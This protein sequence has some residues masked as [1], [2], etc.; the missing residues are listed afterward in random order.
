MFI[1]DDGTLFTSAGFRLGDA[2]GEILEGMVSWGPEGALGDTILQPVFDFEP[3]QLSAWDE[4]GRAASTSVPFSP[5]IVWN[6]SHNRDVICGISRDYRFEIRS[7]DGTVTIIERDHEPTEV[8]ADEKLWYERAKIAQMRNI[9]PGWV[10]NGPNIRNHKPAYDV[11]HPD[12]SDRI[13]V[14]RPG[15]GVQQLD[16]TEDP[17]AGGDWYRNPRWV[18]SFY[19]D[20]FSDDGRFLGEVVIPE[21]F[22]FT[23]PPYIKDDMVIGLI[24]D[25]EGFQTVKRFR[26]VLPGSD[27]R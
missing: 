6:I 2:A 20:V 24:E 13:W 22:Q 4:T 12:L 3:E 27:D 21:G 5:T 11:L 17:L 26:L 19:L 10:W 16:G 14:R 25:E 15:P 9:Q 7:P 23:P 8:Q 1:A 18:D